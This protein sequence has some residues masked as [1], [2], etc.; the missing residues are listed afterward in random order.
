MTLPYLPIGNGV[1]LL[2]YVVVS[3]YYISHGVVASEHDNLIDI[4]ILISSPT[5]E[6]SIAMTL[7]Y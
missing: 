7:Q 5:V 2:F 3:L 6:P 4:V 1:I